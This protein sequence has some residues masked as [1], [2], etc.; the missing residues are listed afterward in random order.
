MTTDVVLSGKSIF[1]E[2][3]GCVRRLPPLQRSLLLLLLL[4]QQ[5]LNAPPS[6]RLMLRRPFSFPLL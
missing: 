4:L 2:D 1:C 6:S 3:S 5:L